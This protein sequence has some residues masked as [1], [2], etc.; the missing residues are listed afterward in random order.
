LVAAI[1]PTEHQGGLQLLLF[2]LLVF[3]KRGIKHDFSYKLNFGLSLFNIL[4]GLI[5]YFFLSRVVSPAQLGPFASNPA[6]FI[7][8]GSTFATFVSVALASYAG[9][10]RT[11][12]FMGTIEQWLLSPSSLIRLI[13]LST[14]WEFLWPTIST[15]FTF[16]V[17]A[18]LLHLNFDINWTTT[19]VFFL[20]TLVAMSG[21]GLISAGFIMVSKTGDPISTLWG[22]VTSLL[23]GTLFPITVLPGWMQSI[24]QVLPTYHAL[25]GL[26]P[27]LI[28][29][30]SIAQESHELLIMAL[31]SVI[32]VPIGLLS[33]KIGFEHARKAGTL[34]QF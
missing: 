34:G 30:A 12:M 8:V 22:V 14:V 6:A 25:Q 13:A 9:S 19:L 18:V 23:S 1:E 31:F 27:A 17:L 16:V 32:V 7:I 2:Q 5:S 3:L 21:F 26:R 11:E 15:A 28:N 29:H 10:L 33:F 4:V 24:S 20:L